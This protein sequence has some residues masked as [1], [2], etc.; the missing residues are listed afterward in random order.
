M[1][2][3]LRSQPE[4]F[5]LRMSLLIVESEDYKLPAVDTGVWLMTTKTKSLFD[6][7]ALL[8]DFTKLAMCER[9]LQIEQNL[10][11]FDYL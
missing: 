2:S 11:H 8:I 10:A 4:G 5:K 1:T 9:A 3:L 6:M 7:Y